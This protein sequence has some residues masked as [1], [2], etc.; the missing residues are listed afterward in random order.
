MADR[1]QVT[2]TTSGRRSGKPRA[3]TIYSFPDGAARIVVGSHGG[4][5]EDPAWVGNLRAEPR[6]TVRRGT[7]TSQVRARELGGPER[8]RAW[9]LVCARF[10]LYARYQRKTERR[11]PLFLLEPADAS[12]AG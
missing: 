12:D 2:L 3:V 7:A 8:D 10:P 11:I 6:A 9:A 4:A 5:D 1:E